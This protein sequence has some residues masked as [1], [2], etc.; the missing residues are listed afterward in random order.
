VIE[1][2]I[3]AVV[4]AIAEHEYEVDF[5][6]LNCSGVQTLKHVWQRR[7]IREVIV[8][9]GTVDRWREK[10]FRIS[11]WHIRFKDSNLP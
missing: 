8:R 11:D 1:L 6:L 4:V 2:V 5:R 7:L 9:R 10:F 3:L